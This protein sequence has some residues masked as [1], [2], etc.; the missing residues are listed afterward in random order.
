MVNVFRNGNRK[1]MHQS[2][3][4][5]GDVMDIETGMEIPAD[6]WFIS[7]SDVTCD[8][9]AMTGETDP[10]VKETLAECLTKK[11]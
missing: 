4:L 6:G 10:M 1:T 3:V 8:E 7:G 9:S 2:E 11:M 5:V